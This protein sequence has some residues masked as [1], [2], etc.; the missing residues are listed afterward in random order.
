MNGEGQVTVTL[1]NGNTLPLFWEDP[2][3]S[4]EAPKRLTGSVK[5]VENGRTTLLVE[6][7]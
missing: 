1:N 4:G 7:P 6:V 3:L 5:K 2:D